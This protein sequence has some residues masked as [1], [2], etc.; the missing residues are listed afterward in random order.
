[1]AASCPWSLLLGVRFPKFRWPRSS[2][3]G[4]GRGGANERKKRRRPG[5][6]VSGEVVCMGGGE[7][8]MDSL[9]CGG[10]RARQG[11]T[12]SGGKALASSSS[13]P[14]ARRSAPT[15]ARAER[16]REGADS[17]RIRIRTDS[18]ESRESFAG[19]REMSESMDPGKGAWPRPGRLP[20][21]ATGRRPQNRPRGAGRQG[22]R[23]ELVRRGRHTRGA[24]AP[25]GRRRRPGRGRRCPGPRGPR[26]RDAGKPGR[27]ACGGGGGGGGGAGARE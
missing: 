13:A 5:G 7:V 3:E 4:G 14:S 26:A 24:R 8:G 6:L 9:A 23:G 10:G 25:S 18:E 20:R 11:P 21:K 17:I 12:H 19:W 1:M 27:A 16:E 22:Q 2:A 15:C